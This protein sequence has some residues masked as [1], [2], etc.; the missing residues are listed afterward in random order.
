MDERSCGAATGGFAFTEGDQG[1]VN[2]MSEESL[3]Q[4][5][6]KLAAKACGA[7]GGSGCLEGPGQTEA[8]ATADSVGPVGAAMDQDTAGLRVAS[9]SFQSSIPGYDAGNGGPSQCSLSSSWHCF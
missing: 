7:E 9:A 2:G 8:P 4:K 3:R 6:D 5:A 1:R